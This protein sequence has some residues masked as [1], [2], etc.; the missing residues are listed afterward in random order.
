M[1]RS[2]TRG[3]GGCGCLRR[4]PTAARGAARQPSSTRRREIVTAAENIRDALDLPLSRRRRRGRTGTRAGLID[5]GP[6]RIRQLLRGTLPPIVQEDHLR[7]S[8]GHMV[9]GYRGE[10]GGCVQ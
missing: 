10:A 2:T 4:Q 6:E 8:S 1:N 3:V 9:E 5:G 7:V